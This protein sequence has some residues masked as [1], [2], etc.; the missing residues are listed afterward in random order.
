MYAIVRERVCLGFRLVNRTHFMD[1]EYRNENDR[2]C[3]ASKTKERPFGGA[4]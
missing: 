2:G 3:H 4:L 1:R